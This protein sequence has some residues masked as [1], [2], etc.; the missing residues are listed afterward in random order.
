MTGLNTELAYRVLRHVQEHPDQYDPGIYI[1]EEPDRITADFLGH[2]CLISGDVPVFLSGRQ[3]TDQV[4]VG[5]DR[6]VGV[7]GGGPP[8]L[9]GA[10]P[11]VLSPE[12]ASLIRLS[13]CTAEELP[14][15]VERLF[16][17]EPEGMP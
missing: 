3:T 11:G 15:V 7:V 16:G 17:P 10:A 1:A 8:V 12:Y 4:A 14:R 2:T 5:G 13:T 9:R 6:C